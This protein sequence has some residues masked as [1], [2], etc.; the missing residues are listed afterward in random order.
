MTRATAQR[1]STGDP[2][3]M[4]LMNAIHAHRDYRSSH[5][6]VSV[7]GISGGLINPWYEPRH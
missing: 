6:T 1:L 4:A 7:D 2:D 3:V 5:Q